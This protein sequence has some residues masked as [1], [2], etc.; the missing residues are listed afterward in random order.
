MRT[1]AV[2]SLLC[3]LLAA[4]TARAE[5]PPAPDSPPPTPFQRSVSFGTNLPF[6]WNDANSIAAS[7]SVSVA[8]RHAIRA[9]VATYKNHG[10]ALLNL[11]AL[12]AGGSEIDHNGRFTDASINWVYYPR[13]AWSGLLLEAGALRRRSDTGTFDSFTS[14]EVVHTDTVIYA[15]RAMLG[16]SWLMQQHV[17]FAAGVGL[18]V[19]RESGIQ[20]ATYE[21][22]GRMTREPIARLHLSGEGYVRV[23]VVFGI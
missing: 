14:P 23:G 18:S 4:T 5:A 20:R 19:G 1:F 22:D 13:R 12:P 9:N 7:L 3:V 8:P 10:S 16:W 21:S 15:A 17:F 11:A 6:L 2:P